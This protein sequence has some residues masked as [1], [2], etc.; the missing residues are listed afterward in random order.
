MITADHGNDPTYSGTD[1]TRETVPLLCYST[2]MKHTK[3]LEEQET[4]AVI[5]ATIAENFT[6]DLL[7][8][9]IGDSLLD[10]IK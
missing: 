10:C 9:M 3:Q 5:G 1:H 4:F 8:H 6:V 7:P 2:S